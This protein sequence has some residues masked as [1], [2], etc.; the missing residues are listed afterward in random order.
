VDVTYFQSILNW[1][2][3]GFSSTLTIIL[4]SIWSVIIYVL[5]TGKTLNINSLL[6]SKEELINDSLIDEPEIKKT[7]ISNSNKR[8]MQVVGFFLF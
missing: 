8:I 5:S 6:N 7:S 4:F 2:T 3:L 1:L